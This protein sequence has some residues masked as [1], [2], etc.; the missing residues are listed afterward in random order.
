M[1]IHN[2]VKILLVEDDE[3]D[4]FAFQDVEGFRGV[5]VNMQRRTEAGWLIGLEQSE[6]P[7][8]FSAARFIHSAGASRAPWRRGSAS[9]PAQGRVRQRGDE[10]RGR[11]RPEAA[12][13][14]WSRSLWAR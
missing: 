1:N 6:A 7:R 14:R 8:G 9:R 11:A 10:G 5:A 4:V 13:G 12:G 2:E 3:D